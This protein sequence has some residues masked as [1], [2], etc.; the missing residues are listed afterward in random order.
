M[1]HGAWIPFT[2]ATDEEIVWVGYDSTQGANR[3]LDVLA[4]QDP[5]C[6]LARPRHRRDRRA[7][8]KARLNAAGHRRRRRHVAA[9][10]DA[11]SGCPSWVG[12][13]DIWLGRLSRSRSAVLLSRLSQISH[14]RPPG[15]RG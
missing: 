9:D 14:V 7:V 12:L 15:H 5:A 8:G 11:I 10:V 2:K 13:P 1:L 6:R 3:S 4:W